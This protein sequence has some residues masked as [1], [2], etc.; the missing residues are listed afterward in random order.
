MGRMYL[1]RCYRAK[2]GKRHAYWALVESVRTARGPRQQVVAYLGEMDEAGRLGIEQAAEGHRRDPQGRLFGSPPARYMQV[3][4]EAVRVENVRAFGGP[5]LGWQILRQ[6]GLMDRLD[7]LIEPGRPEVPWPMMAWVLVLSRLCEP[8]SELHIAEHFYEHSAI[9]DLVGV[10]AEKVNDDRLYRT[11]DAILPHKADLEQHLKER[12]GALFGLEYDLLLY[13]VTSTYFEG[14]AEGNALAQRGYSRDHRPDCKQV[15][16]GLVVTPEGLPIG[17][18]V[19]AGHR[20]DVTTL[21][22][23]VTTMEARYGRAQRI[24]VLD[25]GLVSEQNLAFLRQQGRRYIVGT[26][27]SLLKQFERPLLEEDWET[28]REGLQVKRCPGPEGLETFLLCR[29]ADRQAKER[30]MHERFERRIEEGLA[31]IQAGGRRQRCEPGRIERRVGRLLGLNPR[32]AGLFEVTVTT[33]GRGAARLD[34]HR[35]EAWRSWATLSEGCYVLRS[36]VNDWTGEQLWRAY[37]QLATGAE[38]AFRIHKSD[39]ELRPIW[40]QKAERVQAHILVCFLAYVVWKTLG[41]LCRRAGLGD[42][43]RQVF[44]E[45]ARIAV[46]DVVLPTDAGIE[47]RKRCVQRP[48]AHQAI[49]L[50]RLGLPLPTRLAT[51]AG[52]ADAAGGD[53]HV[54]EAIQM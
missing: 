39:L 46:V 2:E 23:I 27:K 26:P 21:E 19:F 52:P 41:Q 8:S 54:V 20:T 14:L 33:D 47:I 32:A 11:L 7:R 6:L 24:W 45:I 29:S 36:N 16:I 44:E 10:P 43:P 30:A 53:P 9:A 17:Y 42:E 51:W 35:R 3:D 38:G 28:V 40:H 50:E 49:L 15:C 31:Q 22:E 13:D 25:R 37:I 48:T 34:W 5:W 4:V 12:L 18:E 1:R